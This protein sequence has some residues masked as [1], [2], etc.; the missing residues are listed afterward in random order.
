MRQSDTSW[1]GYLNQ[2]DLDF[3]HYHG[4]KLLKINHIHCIWL[5]SSNASD[6]EVCTVL[7]ILGIYIH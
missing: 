5:I 4:I 6:L 1:V 3:L 2:E 7:T